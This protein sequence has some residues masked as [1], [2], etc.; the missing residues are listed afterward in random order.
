MQGACRSESFTPEPPPSGCVLGFAATLLC[1]LPPGAGYDS[2]H[3]YPL[4]STAQHAA[5][6]LRPRMAD[7]D[8]ADFGRFLTVQLAMT[9]M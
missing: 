7:G 1:P 2:I 3:A 8:D 9:S 6:R 5:R 4:I